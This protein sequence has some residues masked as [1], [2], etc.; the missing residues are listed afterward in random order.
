MKTWQGDLTACS[1]DTRVDGMWIKE[2]D[3]R[4]R[5]VAFCGYGF[6]PTSHVLGE[7]LLPLGS[8]H[9]KK[10]L[11]AS[12]GSLGH[13]TGCPGIKTWSMQLLTPLPF[14]ASPDVEI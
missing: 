3:G 14:C 10:V 13:R 4:P 2:T 12:G 5:R 11:S 8:K 7:G 1:K 9:P 6:P